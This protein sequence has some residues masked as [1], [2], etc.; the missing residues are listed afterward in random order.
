VRRLLVL[1]LAAALCGVATA[2]AQ[3]SLETA[4]R[5]EL[6][7]IRRQAAE[8]REAAKRLRGQ[9]VKE[10]GQLKRTERALS[11]TRQRL[12]LLQRRRQNLDSQ[13]E[14][15]RINV[16]RSMESLAGQRARLAKRLRDIYK[17]GPAR[18]VEVLLSTQS[19]GQLLA[20]WDY[21]LMIAEQDRLLLEDVRSR[22]EEVETLERRLQ[23]HLVQIDRTA[24]QTT[25]ENRRLAAQREERQTVVRNIQNQRAAYEAAAEELEKTARA[26]Q[27]LIAQLELKRR[28]EAERARAQGRE[29]QP[30]TGDFARGQGAL[31]WPV[32]G[33]LVGHFGPEKHPRFG[34]TTLNNGVDIATPIGTPVHAVA[35]GRVDYTSEDYGTYGQMVIVNHGDGYYTLYCHLSEIRVSVGQEVVAAQVV[36]LSGDTGSLKGAILHFEVRR[37]GSALNPEDWLQ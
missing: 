3:D 21:L 1:V 23:D 7:E 37:G 15:T 32:R 34:T 10:V 25:S 2:A 17:F 26:V 22:K 33:S 11:Q 28:Q 16:Q 12:R 36:G 8:K 4:K 29:V 5:L 14:I 30:Y 13:L 19:F 9:E 35:K 24:R 27:K 18:E 20:R 31:D 6:E